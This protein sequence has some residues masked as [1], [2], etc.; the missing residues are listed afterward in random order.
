MQQSER[1]D[2]RWELAG[3]MVVA[4]PQEGSTVAVALRAASVAVEVRREQEVERRRVCCSQCSRD[5]TR[6]R[7]RW[8]RARRRRICRPRDMRT[9]SGRSRSVTQ[10][11]SA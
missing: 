11:A 2:S 1:A 5:R 9:Y 10:N 6:S 4:A 8:I 3:S 7:Y